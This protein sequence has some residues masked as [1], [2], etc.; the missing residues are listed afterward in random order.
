MENIQCLPGVH[1]TGKIRVRFHNDVSRFILVNA[2]GNRFTDEGARRDLLKEAVLAQPGKMCFSVIDND[3][4]EYDL[5]MRR[6]AIRGIE[7]GDAF[8]R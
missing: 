5:L 2:E 7:T 3:G 6:D 1:P 4:F 8:K